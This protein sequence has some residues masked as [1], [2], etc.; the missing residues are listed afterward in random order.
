MSRRNPANKP[1][2]SPPRPATLSTAARR[3]WQRLAPEAKRL[4]TLTPATSRAFALLA[5]VLA[6]ERAAAAI[7]AAEGLIVRS[8]AS[9]AKP[10]PAVRSLE[11]ARSQA[12]PLLRQFGLVP[13]APKGAAPTRAQSNGKST[14]QGV[15]S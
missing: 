12:M 9:T 4:G 10:H 11:I 1:T 5:E 8:A 6:T 15:L 14:W 7:V 3:E 13:S 2:R